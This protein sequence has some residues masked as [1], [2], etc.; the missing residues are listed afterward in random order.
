MTT[1]FY[2][3]ANSDF[4]LD[5]FLFLDDGPAAHGQRIGDWI[6]QK[7]GGEG[8]PWT[9]SGRFGLRQMSHVHAWQSPKREPKD[10]GV[11]DRIHY[12]RSVQ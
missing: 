5:K 2:A 4:V 6:V 9:D 3:R 1:R 8:E 7:M 10:K 11:R 12:Y